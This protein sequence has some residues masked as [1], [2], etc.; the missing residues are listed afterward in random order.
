MG[1][2]GASRLGASVVCGYGY[3]CR[4]GAGT[5]NNGVVDVCVIPY[6]RLLHT[7]ENCKGG[8]QKTRQIPPVNH[9]LMSRA[10]LQI[11]L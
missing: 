2:R 6:S 5:N 8:K 11:A 7:M 10:D 9:Y 3:A 1:A 4:L